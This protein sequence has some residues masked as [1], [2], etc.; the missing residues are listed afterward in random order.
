MKRNRIK[1]I[2]LTNITGEFT[3]NDK[4]EIKRLKKCLATIALNTKRELNYKFLS[5]SFPKIVFPVLKY[6]KH[7]TCPNFSGNSLIVSSVRKIVCFNDLR[8]LQYISLVSVRIR[9]QLC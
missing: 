6:V 3:M 2:C 1:S 9:S 7:F 5:V 4:R 8:S